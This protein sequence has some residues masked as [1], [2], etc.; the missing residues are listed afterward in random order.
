MLKTNLLKY[1]LIE[2]LYVARVALF[3]NILEIY[4]AD[5]LPAAFLFNIVEGTNRRIV[6]SIK[7]NGWVDFDNI[8]DRPNHRSTWELR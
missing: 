1:I 3:E 2:A 6:I 8:F 4:I 7:T 5:L